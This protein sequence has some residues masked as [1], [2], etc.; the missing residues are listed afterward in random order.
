MFYSRYIGLGITN[1]GEL[2]SEK[3]L[4]NMFLKSMVTSQQK[5]LND[6]EISLFRKPKDCKDMTLAKR[7]AIFER[8]KNE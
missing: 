6:S 7:L 8:N 2:I 4:D 1:F 3:N 5:V